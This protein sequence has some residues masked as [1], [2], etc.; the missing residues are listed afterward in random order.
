MNAAPAPAEGVLR[1]DWLGLTRTQLRAWFS[2]QGQKAY[3]ADQVFKWLHRQ[4]VTDFTAMTDLAKPLRAFLLAQHP[5]VLPTLAHA[6]LAGD[7]TRKWL[8]ALADGNQIETVFIPS[9]QRGTLCVSSQVGC[10]LNCSFCATA[11]Q[12]FNRNLTAAEIVAQLWLATQALGPGMI[13]NI[14]FM[15][16]G[17]PLLNLDAVLTAVDIMRDDLSYNLSRRRVTLS[18]SGV[19]PGILQLVART[20]VSLAIS[21]HAPDDVLR[22]QLVPL[23]RK[24]PL[25]VL[26][27]ACAQYVACSP[28]GTIT[29]EYILLSGINDQP[30]HAQALLRLLRPLPAKVNLIP[31]NPFPAT[32]YQRS[33]PEAVA[34]FGAILHQAGLRTTTRRTR[35]DDIAAACGQLAGDFQDR[36][37]RRVHMARWAGQVT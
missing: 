8:M 25:A 21:L 28:K 22:D 11:R 27:D 3:H 10:A 23:N 37:R 32:Q 19:V 29:F 18:T 12:G 31:F 16:M 26:L 36:T 24:Y 34:K 35:G 15:G 13:T 17:E 2:Q 14:V 4:Q 30:H 6:H 1:P 7:G 9:A 5:V 20:D 33:T